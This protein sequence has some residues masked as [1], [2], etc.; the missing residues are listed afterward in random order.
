MVNSAKKLKW[1]SEYGGPIELIL[2]PLM[3]KSYVSVFIS[4]VNGYLDIRSGV[5]IYYQ[6]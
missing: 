5:R 3:K 4:I 1:V 6:L 2:H